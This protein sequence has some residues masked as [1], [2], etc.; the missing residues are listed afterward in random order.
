MCNNW[1]GNILIE[2]FNDPKSFDNHL[3]CDCSI[4][5]AMILEGILKRGG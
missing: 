5:L 1:L 2:M 3:P 4:F